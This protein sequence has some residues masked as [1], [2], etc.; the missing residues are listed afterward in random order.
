MWLTVPLCVSC[1]ACICRQMSRNRRC[2]RAHML[3]GILPGRG[4][5]HLSC[6]TSA[7]LH[8]HSHIGTDPG[9]IPAVRRQDHLGRLRPAGQQERHERP[10]FLPVQPVEHGLQDRAHRTLRRVRGPDQPGCPAVQRL[11]AHHRGPRHQHQC[12]QPHLPGWLPQ[13]DES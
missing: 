8:A 11:L 5:F 9:G 4:H 7:L 2:H 6:L 12:Q 13:G 10:A 1:Y 3:P